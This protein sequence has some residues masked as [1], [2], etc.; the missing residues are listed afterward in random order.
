MTD[1]P[2]EDAD[3]HFRNPDLPPDDLP[4]E[5]GVPAE[6]EVIEVVHD[7]PGGLKKKIKTFGKG[8]R[9]E[10]KWS[11]TPNATG[12]GA[13]HVQTFFSKLTQDSV[14]YMDQS[15]NEWLDEHPEYEVKF[16]NSSIGTMRG[17]MGPQEVIICQ[18]WV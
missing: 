9:H 1:V 7:S 12:E 17:K 15:I 13:I 4:K 14:T 8:E 18:V 3:K 2:I 5:G 16:V 10:D 11:R 6:D